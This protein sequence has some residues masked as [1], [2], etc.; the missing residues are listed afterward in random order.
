MRDGARRRDLPFPQRSNFSTAQRHAG[1]QK[2]KHN[3][4]SYDDN[5]R[6]AAFPREKKN[7]NAPDYSGPLNI[8]GKELEISIWNK[9]S[10][11]G[12]EFLSIKVGPPWK[13]K[14]KTD[15]NAPK[16]AA[17]RVTDEPATDDDIPF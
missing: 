4:Q 13:P 15:Y 14:E 9:T 10:K 16:P 8:E 5:N 12:N 7:P 2:H 17:P 6:G 11:A 1:Y 3:M